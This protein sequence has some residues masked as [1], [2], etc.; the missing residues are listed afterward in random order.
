ML[1]GQVVEGL[2]RCE[3][4]AASNVGFGHY[5]KVVVGDWALRQS[6]IKALILREVRNDK[7]LLDLRVVITEPAVFIDL[8]S[9]PFHLVVDFQSLLAPW[10]AILL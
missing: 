3:L 6:D 4:D 2:L 8:N 10:L 7:L 9:D 1:L 5:Q